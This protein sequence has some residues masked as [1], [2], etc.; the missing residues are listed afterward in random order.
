MSW[1]DEFVGLPYGDCGRGPDAWDCWGLVCK[2]FNEM[3]AIDLPSYASDYVDSR[4]R[5]ESSA[6]IEAENCPPTWA[7]VDQPEP[8][9]LALFRLG[10]HRCHVGIIV[11]TPMMLHMA[12]GQYAKIEPISAPRWKNRL[13]G[14]YRHHLL[15]PE[16]AS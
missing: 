8:F 9:D 10:A 2:V 5:D 4:E 13:L 14:V 3:L 7:P 11:A 16:A 15:V 1:A 6:L 12:H